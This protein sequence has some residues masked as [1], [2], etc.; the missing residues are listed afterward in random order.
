MY[1]ATLCGV[2]STVEVTTQQMGFK[3]KDDPIS[4][5]AIGCSKSDHPEGRYVESSHPPPF[6]QSLKLPYLT[7]LRL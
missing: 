5:V 3:C 2:I 4:S 6:R 1:W 7:A